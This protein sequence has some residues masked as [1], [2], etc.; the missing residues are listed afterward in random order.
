[1]TRR[2]TIRSLISLLTFPVILSAC[3]GSGSNSNSAPSDNTPERS[4]STGRF[5]DSA[6]EGLEYKSGE[7]EGITD[8]RGTFEYEQIDGISQPVTFSFNGVELG[9]ALGKTVVTPLDLVPNSDIDDIEVQNIARFIQMLDNDENP[10]NG[11]SP[12]MDLITAMFSFVWQPLNFSDIDFENQPAVTQIIADA[13]SVATR[14]YS[15][16]SAAQATSHLK[17]TVACQ[18]SGVF[19][20]QFSGDD[21]GHFVLWVQH[22]RVDPNSFGDNEAHVGVTSA[23]VYSSAEDRLIGVSPQEGLEFNSRNS[24]VAGHTNNGAEFTG[25][26]ID[27]NT[28]SNGVWRNDIEGG[29][30]AFSG[31]RIAGDSTAKYRLGGAVGVLNIFEATPD[32]TGAIALDIFA[33]NRVSGVAI[34]SRG[35]RYNLIGELQGDSITLTSTEGLTV[36][37]TYDATGTHPEN[38]AVGL[39]GQAG[40]WGE[41]QLGSNSGVLVGTSCL[42][43][44]Q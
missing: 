17:Q 29:K 22:Q 35:D 31:A 38:N 34:S 8:E 6:V 16:P 7:L 19:S 12:S 3:G 21:T 23:F 37:L 4:T 18:S 14:S 26:L 32:N 39:Y 30:G 15:L 36:N 42:L 27:Y 11:I 41:W 44:N 10:N 28:I 25:D 1:M 43:N 5:L 9:T 40:F 33:D 2:I 20:G 24:F 13:S